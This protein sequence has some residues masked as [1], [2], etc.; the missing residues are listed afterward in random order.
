LFKGDVSL[1]GGIGVFNRLLEEFL[2]YCRFGFREGK[3]G[4]MFLLVV[5]FRW[6]LVHELTSFTTSAFSL[7]YL[8]YQGHDGINGLH[9]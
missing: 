8:L 1:S 5:Y 4:T 9:L 3:L 7:P 6:W 2:V